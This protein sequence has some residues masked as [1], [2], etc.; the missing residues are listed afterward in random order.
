MCSCPIESN[1][2]VVHVHKVSA[3]VNPKISVCFVDAFKTSPQQKSPRSSLTLVSPRFWFIA[4]PELLSVVTLYNFLTPTPEHN[5][6]SDVKTAQKKPSFRAKTVLPSTAVS[7]LY[8]FC[9][10]E[11]ENALKREKC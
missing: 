5:I 1:Q 3:T 4:Q 2:A 8:F 9:L 10:E 7:F 11:I 6:S